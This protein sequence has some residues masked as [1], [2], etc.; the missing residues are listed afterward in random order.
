MNPLLPLVTNLSTRNREYVVFVGAGFSKD[1]G[2]KSGWDILIETLIPIYSDDKELD[3]L[4]DGCYSQVEE[5][6]LSHEELNQLGY[7]E[8]LERLYEGEIERR[9]H[10]KKFF[11]GQQPGEAHRQLA[12]MVQNQLVRF[13]FTT[14][15]DDLIEKSLEE[16][17]IDFDVIYSD[18]ILQA[19]KS[20]DKV[21]T[22]RIYK[23]HGDYKAGKIRNTKKELMALD[24]Y[25]SEDFQYIIDRHGLIVIGYAGRDEGIMQHFLERRPYHYPFYW[26]F[27]EYPPQTDEFNLYYELEQ[28]YAK[29]YQREI[30]YIKNDSAASFLSEVNDGI[31]RLE[32]ILII[33]ENDR[34]KFRNFITQNNEQKIKTFTIDIFKQFCD[35]LEEY[36]EKENLNNFVPYKFEIFEELTQEIDFLFIYVDELISYRMSEEAEFLLVKLLKHFTRTDFHYSCEFIENSLPYYLFMNMGAIFFRNEQ[37][38]FL[39]FAFEHRFQSSSG[40]SDL[41]MS[42]ISWQVDDAWKTI[43]TDKYRQNYYLPKY[44]VIRNSLLPPTIPADEFDTFDAFVAMEIIIR[45]L[46]IRWLCGSVLCHENFYKTFLKFFSPKIDSKDKAEKFIDKMHSKLERDRGGFSGTRDV[47]SFLRK[48]FPMD[49]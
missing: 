33:S 20:W 6:Y 30:H 47:E 28:K 34:T 40:N 26:Q 37:I 15:F 41:F 36:E 5:W 4:P 12:R 7:S 18:D 16:I 2:V 42:K 21:N 29:D 22:C 39:K 3:S 10:L 49:E 1:A 46:P 27:V 45:D 11:E 23:L 9:E 43:G 8:I 24:P 32:R 48:K 25:I 19:T 38:N 35:L 14:N 31:D 17:G 13:I 44:F